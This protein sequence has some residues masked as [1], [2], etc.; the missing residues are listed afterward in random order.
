M[1]MPGTIPVKWTD[2]FVDG[3]ALWLSAFPDDLAEATRASCQQANRWVR[4]F[5][6]SVS[7]GVQDRTLRKR[8]I[9]KA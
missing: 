3:R 8:Q 6:E 2:A 7:S 1:A 9:G 5:C 4:Q